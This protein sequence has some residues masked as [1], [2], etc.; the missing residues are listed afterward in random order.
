[1]DPVS[2][3]LASVSPR[4][5]TT[6]RSALDV[7]AR[8][9]S[10]ERHDASS[11]AWSA[12]DGPTAGA[13]RWALAER[14]SDASVNKALAALRRVSTEAARLGAIDH[15]RL[16]RIVA[17]RPVRR[18]AIPGLPPPSAELLRALALDCAEDP[19]IA[20]LRDAALVTIAFGGAIHL[21]EACRLRADALDE[22]GRGLR[23]AG[24][25]GCLHMSWAARRIVSRWLAVRGRT[26]GPLV[27]P[28]ACGRVV[29]RPLTPAEAAAALCER[30]RRAQGTGTRETAA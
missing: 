11:F 16:A 7:I 3:Y 23:M 15:E 30:A 28:V 12:L 4:S 14:T 1:M 2:A 13:I 24:G 5:R 21:D 8:M 26:V 17:V 25:A 6:L 29:P 22:A 9:A 19:S 20:G 27:T 18:S 10:D